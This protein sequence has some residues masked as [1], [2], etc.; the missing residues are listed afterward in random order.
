MVMVSMEK[1]STPII[2]TV[3]N[4]YL[5]VDEDSQVVVDVAPAPPSRK[6]RL[7]H[8]TWEEKMQRKKL[9]NRVA[10]QT[11]RDRKKAKMDE[12]ES[13]IQHFMETNERLIAE[14]ENLK[15]MN[16]RLLSENAALRSEAAARTVAE[17]PRPAEGGASDGDP[18]GAPAADDV[19]PLADLLASLDSDDYLDQLHQLADSLLKEISAAAPGETADVK[20]GIA[21]ECP[22][23]A[24]VVGTATK[25]LEPGQSGVIDNKHDIKRILAQ[26]SYAHPYP[27]DTVQIK[28]ENGDKG[29]M[30]YASCE[31]NDCVTIEVPC[32]DQVVE[33][34]PL[35]SIKIDSSLPSLNIDTHFDTEFNELT[36]NCSEV[37]LECDMKLLSPMTLSPKS[38][39][40]NLLGLSPS[41]TNFSSDLGYESL[42]S[43]L[44]EPE[45]MDLSDF[46]CES[47]SELFPGLA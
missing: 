17:A 23:G 35:P 37:T 22:Q 10:A 47:F 26:H 16:E 44:S 27:I 5:A 31:E 13:R 45:S 12:M 32:E 21:G 29:D 41:H 40:E 39:E 36:N 3:P 28:E 15:A 18:R 34:T 43:P 11:S 8:L 24:E 42:S 33:E 6:R 38:M 25:Q 46:W 20:V 30:F 14:V 9:K 1:M 19:S 7:D 4:N 2:I